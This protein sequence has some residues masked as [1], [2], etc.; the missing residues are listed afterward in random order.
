MI[1]ETLIPSQDDLLFIAEWP[2]LRFAASLMP[3][4]AWFDLAM[5]VER[6]K[7]LLGFR[8][9]AVNAKTIRRALG[10][11]NDAA[12]MNISLRLRAND[13]E[14]FIQVLKSSEGGWNPEIRIEGRSYLD[15]AISK[16]KGTILWYMPFCF[17]MAT[18]IGLKAA[19]YSLTRTSHRVHG[20][21]PGPFAVRFLN[22]QWICAEDRYLHKR[23]TIDSKKPGA[24][25]LRVQRELAN[26][27]IVLIN[28][29]AWSGQ[30][31]VSAPILGGW[32]PLAVGAPGLAHRIGA[33][34]LPVFTIR[35]PGTSAFLICIGSL[36]PT[37]AENRATAIND[38]VAALVTQM[39]VA[40]RRT[41]D[42]WTSWEYLT[43][44]EPTGNRST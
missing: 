18:I 44:D 14:K 40:V 15:A 12:A 13:T 43:F 41:P 21:C 28:I 23:V 22:P 39:E 1:D 3:E 5:R 11:T 4:R 6:A 35:M 34:L 36:L 38:S 9:S 26:N 8:D 30:T 17:S 37:D 29:G 25:L 24:A 2:I 7:V 27:G 31:I 19:G 20:F 16:G 33:A 32:L 10:L 42:Q